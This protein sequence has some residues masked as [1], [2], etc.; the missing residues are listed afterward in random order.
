MSL[1]ESPLTRF[2]SIIPMKLK[3]RSIPTKPRFTRLLPATAFAGW[4]AF[5]AA[6]VTALEPGPGAAKTDPLGDARKQLSQMFDSPDAGKPFENG[7]IRYVPGADRAVLQTPCYRLVDD[8]GRHIELTGV[9]HVGEKAYYD[10]LNEHL[11]TFDAVLFEL[12]ADADKVKA[13][14]SGTPVDGAEKEASLSVLYRVLAH[15]L[16]AMS[17]QM[18][19]INYRRPTFIHA[20]LSATELTDL[21]AKKGMTLDQLVAGQ[22]Q[23]QGLKLDVSQMAKLLPLLK[24]FVPKDDPSALE[25]MM[26]PMFAKMDTGAAQAAGVSH[27]ILIESRNL[28]ALEVLDRELAAGRK[29]LSLF[30]GSGHLPDFKKRLN[31]RGWK[32][33]GVEWRDAW[34]I[35]AKTVA[36]TETAPAPAPAADAAPAVPD[37]AANALL[38]AAF[39]PFAASPGVHFKSRL[40]IKADALGQKI[41][42]EATAEVTAL[43]PN[44]IILKVKGLDG[45]EGTL[46]SDGTT[47]TLQAKGA[48]TY[49]QIPAP[50]TFA[51]FAA[52]PGLAE[53]GLDD[54]NSPFPYLSLEGEASLA[55]AGFT[56]ARLLTPADLEGNPHQRVQLSAQ[57]NPVVFWLRKD[58]PFPLVKMDVDT[59]KLVEQQLGALGEQGAALKDLIKMEAG[60]FFSEGAVA[61]SYPAETFRFT[62]PAGATK[63]D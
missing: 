17:M 50:A 54:G 61:E 42:Q 16:L 39:R 12:V 15:D 11:A 14:Q 3:L 55:T 19:V 49:R 35:P 40:A 22:Q 62:P 13:L 1:P 20:D 44:R 58:A 52:L 60:Q 32:D 63:E 24:L 8:Q 46:T 27:E 38:A 37:E 36:A 7:S 43:K 18:E 6:P 41:E 30:Y 10:A 47:V 33:D 59:A 45:K 9:V 25:R 56:D 26:A 2:H 57:G 51:G 23:A 53:I 21:L 48:D 34:V 5:S 4:L 29:N 31:E 28:R